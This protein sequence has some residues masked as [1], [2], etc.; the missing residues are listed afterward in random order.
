M[1]PALAH[2]EHTELDAES[3]RTLLTAVLRRA[4]HDFALYRHCER[5]ALGEYRRDAYRWL[6]L[7]KASEYKDELDRFMSMERICSVLDLPVENVR[8]AAL[9]LSRDDVLQCGGD[10]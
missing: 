2:Y 8:A 3:V 5:G 9:R 6:F 1:D 7:H 4:V 10:L